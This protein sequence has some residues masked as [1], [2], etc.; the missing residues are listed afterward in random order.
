MDQSLPRSRKAT[1]DHSAQTELPMK[2]LQSTPDHS[3]VSVL[4]REATT[5]CEKLYIGNRLVPSPSNCLSKSNSS[6]EETIQV[7]LMYIEYFCK[8]A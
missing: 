8:L 1:Q 2:L 6:L 7:S 3:H 5:P 4:S